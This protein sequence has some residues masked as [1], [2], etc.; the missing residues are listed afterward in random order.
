L[1]FTALALSRQNRRQGLLWSAAGVM[2]AIAI[3][4]NFYNFISLFLTLPLLFFLFLRDFAP[5]REWGRSLAW[6][7]GGGLATGWPWFYQRAYEQP[8]N[9]RWMGIYP[10]SRMDGWRHHDWFYSIP[11]ALLLFALALLILP[12]FLRPAS[13]YPVPPPSLPQLAIPAWAGAMAWMGPALL[14]MLSGSTVQPNHFQFTLEAIEAF[15]WLAVFAWYAVNFR[16][17][18]PVREGDRKPS[19]PPSDSK[20]LFVGLLLGCLLILGAQARR[21]REWIRYEGPVRLEETAGPGYRSNFTA[22]TA[23]LSRPRYRDC[24]AIA[25]L[26]HQVLVWWVALQRRYAFCPDLM[27][28]TAGQP[29]IECRFALFCHQLNL[30]P[31]QFH[32]LIGRQ[33]VLNLWLSGNEYQL[34]PMHH[35]APLSDYSSQALADLQAIPYGKGNW[36]LILPLSEEQR[37][38]ELYRKTAEIPLSSYPRFD[39]IVLHDQEGW[40]PHLEGPVSADWELAYSND[41]FRVWIRRP[42]AASALP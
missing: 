40:L 32:D 7:I 5:L 8:I 20:A 12:R 33:L 26:N 41:D 25:T 39:L 30:T 36:N 37:L 1:I 2:V 23:E 13:A 27:A 38:M 24:Q 28:T 16:A 29:E 4:S 9:M 11:F 19:A 17:F 3:Q 6:F 21:V 42:S 15:V 14:A 18:I 10:L 22:L 34:S 31:D 35:F